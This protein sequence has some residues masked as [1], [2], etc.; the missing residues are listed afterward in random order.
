MQVSLVLSSFIA[1]ILTF[2]APCTLPLLPGYLGFISGVPLRDLHDKKRV[3][4]ASRR[5][6]INGVAYVVGFTAVFVALGLVAGLAGSYL[7]AYRTWF[8]RV[9]GVL[10]IFFGLYMMHIIRM[11][12]LDVPRNLKLLHTL[13]P[14]YP[15]SSF[16]FGAAFALGWTPCV[17][18]VLG[19]VLTLAAGSATV[20][21]GALLLMV[22]S[23]G[24]GLP[25]LA[26]AAG[27]SKLAEKVSLFEKYLKPVSVVGGAFLVLV[28]IV[29]VMNWSAVWINAAY[30]W[31]NVLGYEKL[32][33]Y[34]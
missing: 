3:A 23:L 13:K 19:T 10:V 14:G 9:S 6:L 11:P 22:F 20:A 15:A 2:L 32:L 7:G 24:L 27:I 8:I 31:L 16:V 33:Q 28:G 1:G 26:V 5:I 4:A 25:F 21:Q 29:L 17:G 18:P 12:A 34:L 30:E